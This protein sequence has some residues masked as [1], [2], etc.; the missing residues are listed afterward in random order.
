MANSWVVQQATQFNA[1]GGN[2]AT[3][4]FPLPLTAGNPILVMLLAIDTGAAL[5]TSPDS[6]WVANYIDPA[7][8]GWIQLSDTQGNTFYQFARIWGDPVNNLT[9][10]GGV[11]IASLAAPA[12][13]SLPGGAD[14]ATFIFTPPISS[15]E[16]CLIGLVAF[17]IFD[18]GYQYAGNEVG[19]S[20]LEGST[21]SPVASDCLITFATAN[22]PA[23]PANGTF[24][25][26]AGLVVTHDGSIL[27]PGP[28]HR[29]DTQPFALAA[30]VATTVNNRKITLGAQFVASPHTS[31]IPY[32]ETYQA[33]F[34]DTPGPGTIINS[35][36]CCFEAAL[37]NTPLAQV[38]PPLFFPPPTAYLSMQSVTLTSP[39]SDAIYYTLDGSPPTN[40][41]RYTGP[42]SVS[43]TTT[44]K[45]VAVKAGLANSPIVGAT[46][47]LPERI[48][49]QTVVTGNVNTILGLS[50]KTNYYKSGTVRFTLV[51]PVGFT[52]RCTPG[53]PDFPGG[54]PLADPLWVDVPIDP[55]GTFSATLQGNDWIVPAGTLYRV[56]YLVPNV[57]FTPR[58]YVIA[59]NK[60][61]LNVALPVSQG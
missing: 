9:L 24:F 49:L 33:S 46:Y 10:C 34:G 42:L 51:P 30:A 38:A 31:I 27:T 15:P 36:T 18:G 43:V 45:A 57:S 44:I 48:G 11:G 60:L 29:S 54:P 4:V 59:G 53:G 7:D 32:T 58:C 22:Y 3:A 12:S 50:P 25:Y 37:Y 2:R 52:G 16:K 6:S 17:E 8:P 1:V 35:Q 19:G 56:S 21:V 28:S 5:D 13:S 14:A 26:A 47:T 61:D 40:S 23:V 55:S 20:L 41:L 39:G